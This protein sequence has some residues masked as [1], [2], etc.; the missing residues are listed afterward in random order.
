MGATIVDILKANGVPIIGLFFH[1]RDPHTGKN[2]KNAMVDNF[3]FE[4]RNDRIK[5]P[6]VV[7]PQSQSFMFRDELSKLFKKHFDQWCALEKLVTSNTVNAKIKCPDEIFDDGAFSDVLGVFAA[8]GKMDPD[9]MMSTYKLPGGTKGGSLF[10]HSSLNQGT[11]IQQF[12]S[13]IQK[14]LKGRKH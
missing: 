13:V 9:N 3:V 1:S 8:D 4:L 12:A 6:N 5:Y 7:N 10:G 14:M 11:G 2:F